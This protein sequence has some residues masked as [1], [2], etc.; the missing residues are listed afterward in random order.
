[1]N[2]SVHSDDLPTGPATRRGPEY[3]VLASIVLIAI[4]L[5]THL[6]SEV[7][8]SFDEACSWKISQFSWTETWNA[9][10]RDAHP[11]LYYAI[12]K[13]WGAL[14]GE[15]AAGVRSFSVLMGAASVIAA[16]AFV[17]TAVDTDESSSAFGP[18]LAAALVAGSALHVEMGLQ[19]RPYTLGTFL[20]LISATFLIRWLRNQGT[21]SD[22][23]LFTGAICLLSFTHYYCLFTVG[24]ECLFAACVAVSTWF[25]MGWKGGA[26]RLVLGLLASLWILQMAWSFWLPVFLDQRERST[27]QLWM[28]PFSW[29]SFSAT[30]G[31]VLAGG[32]L[33]SP[34]EAFGNIAIA[35]WIVAVLG[36]V[37]LGNRTVR[38]AALCAAFPLVAVIAYALMV[39][40]VLGGKYLI[41][42]H[43]FLLVGVAILAARIP[44]KWCRILIAIGLCSWSTYWCLQHA[45]ARNQIA[46]N[47][48]V[49][50]IV[51][52]LKDRRNADEPVL[53]SSQ[54]V[55]PIV[56][57]YLSNYTTLVRTQ[58]FGNH[59]RD[60]LGGPPLRESEYRDNDRVWH[61]PT[62]CVWVVDVY[63]LF[64]EG[65]RLEVEAPQGW[66]MVGQEEFREANG[67]ACILAVREYRR[68]PRIHDSGVV[69]DAPEEGQ[70][71]DSLSGGSNDDR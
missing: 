54:F 17:R 8:F 12:L 58:Y 4:F 48:G 65:N 66:Q 31:Q 16:Y 13:A 71:R 26:K 61:P 70:Q 43:T 14:T 10:S 39:R 20:A 47:A 24:A 11:P 27:S 53:V 21:M 56:Q 9:V 37:F 63:N 34:P 42:A 32:Q 28:E 25:R 41:F 7:T 60:M 22:W 33:V 46:Q 67:L 57:F 40:N 51:R 36:L 15:D 68:E 52:F 45:E 23:G 50:D 30:V 18:L 49:Q 29:S 5:R 62:Q 69:V 38:L 44:W 19:A 64:G 55:H 3:L 59:G 35:A 6:I 1:M 2:S